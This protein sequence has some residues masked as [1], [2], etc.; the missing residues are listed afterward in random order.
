MPI[1]ALVAGAMPLVGD[2]IGGMFGASGQEATNRLQ[3]ELAQRQMD[4]QERMSSTA[5]Q[6]ATADMKAAGLNPLLAFMQGGASSPAGAQ[7]TVGNPGAFIGS[8]VK[9]GVSS[10]MAAVQLRKQ[11][12][13]L[14]SQSEKNR[15]DAFNTGAD[16]VRI[17]QSTSARPGTESLYIQGLKAAVAQ[18]QAAAASSASAASLNRAALP[19]AEVTG[20]K[21]AAWLQLLLRTLTG[22]GSAAKGLVP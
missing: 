11:L 3:E 20:G 1:P 21:G 18:A 4:F 19:G 14:D 2:V 13:V 16:T 8:G 10:A 17:L 12:D 5:Y 7:A 9:E 6:R 15:A 22:V